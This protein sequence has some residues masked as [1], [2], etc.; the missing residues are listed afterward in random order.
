[1]NDYEGGKEEYGYS[2][3]YEKSSNWKI[4]LMFLIPVLII[5]GLVIFAYINLSEDT[6]SDSKF[7]EGATIDLRENKQAD[8]TVGDEKHFVKINSIGLDTVKLTIQSEPIEL[9]IK[10]GEEKEVDINGDG[11][12]DVI[13]KLIEINDGVP[14]VYMRRI[15]EERKEQFEERKNET[16]ERARE[17]F[18]EG[19]LP[20]LEKRIRNASV[21]DLKELENIVNNSL[22]SSVEF[23]DNST[24]V[25]QWYCGSW[26][27]CVNGKQ[28]RDCSDFN[29]CG[30]IG[31]RPTMVR[32]C[33]ISTE[34][35]CTERWSCGDWSSCVN[36]KQTRECIDFNSCGSVLSE[37]HR[38]RNCTNSTINNCTENWECGDWSSCVNGKQIRICED[39]HS[40]RSVLNK[41]DLE[42]NCD[43][44]ISN[45]LE[46]KKEEILNKA[47]E[48][49][50]EEEFLILKEAI[51]NSSSIEELNELDKTIDDYVN[52]INSINES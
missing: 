7:V 51:N 25:G 6:I 35:N 40:C 1:M 30:I 37:Q 52:A 14:K 42:R 49:L 19:D 46:I 38:Q 23:R 18:S 50:P 5:F 22:N 13:V 16:I 39:L 44:D 48:L 45:D 10:I 21:N 12:M 29:S 11:L 47:K 20:E 24:C 33:T 4:W 26:S 15:Y 36:E 2:E 31:N 43:K 9:E 32:N 28:N 3:N 17:I 34:N 8:F 27:N 41:P